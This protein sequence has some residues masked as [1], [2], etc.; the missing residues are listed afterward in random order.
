[1]KVKETGKDPKKFTGTREGGIGDSSMYF[2]MRQ[3][4]GGVFEATL[5]D[6]W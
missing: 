6:D 5:V 4:E 2:V 1:M 3:K